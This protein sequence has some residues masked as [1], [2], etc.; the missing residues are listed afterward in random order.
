MSVFLV[1]PCATRTDDETA[2]GYTLVVTVKLFLAY[3]M[4]RCVIIGKIV[5]HVFDFLLDRSLVSAFLYND[6][7]VSF[8]FFSGRKLGIGAASDGF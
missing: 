6:K 3:K 4:H 1:P 7:A 8:M 2:V 5:G